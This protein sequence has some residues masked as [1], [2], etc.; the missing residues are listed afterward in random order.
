MNIQEFID[1]IYPLDDSHQDYEAEVEVEDEQG[2]TV[3][4]KIKAVRWD[5]NERKA[6]IELE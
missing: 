1:E 2:V 4:C 6:L 5:H 3:P